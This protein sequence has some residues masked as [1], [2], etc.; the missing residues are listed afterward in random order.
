[1]RDP[2]RIPKIIGMLQRAWEDSPDM[3]LGQLIINVAGK[4]DVY[5]VEDEVMQDDLKEWLATS[6][7]SM[8]TGDG[9]IATDGGDNSTP[10]PLAQ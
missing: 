3:R 6:H 8:R 4:T 10:D 2:A 9:P 5:N 1:M 7:W